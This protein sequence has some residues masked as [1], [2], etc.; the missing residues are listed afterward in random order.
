[1]GEWINSGSRSNPS[2]LAKQFHL[3][4]GMFHAIASDFAFGILNFGN[5]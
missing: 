4:M 3:V 1:M 5:S 2:F